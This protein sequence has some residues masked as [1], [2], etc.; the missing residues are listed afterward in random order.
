MLSEQA[1]RAMH[2]ALD[3][4]EPNLRGRPS[5]DP[6][7]LAQDAYTRLVKPAPGEVAWPVRAHMLALFSSG[8]RRSLVDRVR[9]FG[10]ASDEA[11]L[12]VT[13]P[14][15]DPAEEPYAA[16]L[17]ELHDA[18]EA[19][20]RRDSSHGRLADLRIFAG[21]ANREVA[22]VLVSPVASVELDWQLAGS[23]LVGR[24]SGAVAPIT[25]SELT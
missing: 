15:I 5:V 7:T 16:P 3:A 2:D 1:A 11:S 19:L 23:W 20:S 22:E 24:L 9:E 25:D 12:V 14:Y 6:R 8:L 21:L 17:L 13:F 18:I 10:A 4:A